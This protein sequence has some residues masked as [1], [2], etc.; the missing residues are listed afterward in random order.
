MVRDRGRV[1]ERAQLTRAPLELA[2]KFKAKVCFTSPTIASAA[3]NRTLDIRN[4]APAPEEPH[5]LGVVHH[6]L[7]MGGAASGRARGHR[8]APGEPAARVPHK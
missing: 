6:P 4:S 1:T 2:R 7:A 8:T 3:R 5:L